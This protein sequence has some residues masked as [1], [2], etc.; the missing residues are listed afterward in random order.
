MDGLH[1]ASCPDAVRQPD[2]GRPASLE[3]GRFLLSIGMFLGLTEGKHSQDHFNLDLE[4]NK[5]FYLRIA[6]GLPP[7]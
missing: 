2:H 1:R 5:T 7:V 6:C 4:R 3:V